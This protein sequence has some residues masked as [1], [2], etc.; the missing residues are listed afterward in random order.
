MGRT[1]YAG[2]TAPPSSRKRRFAVIAR[3]R[4]APWQRITMSPPA[5]VNIVIARSFSDE[6]TF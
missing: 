6:A 4:K 5:T 3:G 1:G 2:R